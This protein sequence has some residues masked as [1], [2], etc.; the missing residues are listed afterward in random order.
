[1]ERVGRSID[2]GKRKRRVPQTS[3]PNYGTARDERSPVPSRAYMDGVGALSGTV[4][5]AQFSLASNTVLVLAFC[6]LPTVRY[7]ID[8]PTNPA[9]KNRLWFCLG[10]SIAVINV[11]RVE[12]IGW[13]LRSLIDDRYPAART[14]Q[15]R[16]DQIIIFCH[17]GTKL[18]T[19]F[20]VVS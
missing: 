2:S 19:I 3:L 1:M 13:N 15:T 6:L 17:F 16:P 18:R 7:E 4:L 11:N 14:D 9:N 20:V 12:W 10:A 8:L 5:Y